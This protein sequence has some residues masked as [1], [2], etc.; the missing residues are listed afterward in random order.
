VARLVYS[1]IASLDGYI[2][3]ASGDFTW[4]APDDEVHAFVNDRERDIGT[5]LYG[6]RMYY[7]MRFWETSSTDASQ[8][9]V[10]R[11]YAK[12]WRS[13]D[14]V[15]FSTTLREA[16]TERTRLEPVFDAGLVRRMKADAERDLSIGG[17]DLAS[18]ALEAGLVDEVS[19][20]LQP[21]ALGAGKPALPVASPFRFELHEER[22]FRCGVVYMRYDV[23]DPR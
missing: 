9:E 7:T 6:R 4:A 11:D 13:A 18:Q 2:E 5:Y 8:A 19:L 23:R 1:A 22:R 12:I 20:F 3:D 14:K 16:T 15:V 17:P 21:I 10:S